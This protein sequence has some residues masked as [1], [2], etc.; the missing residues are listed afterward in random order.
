MFCRNC[1][2]KLAEGGKF[3]AACGE[4]IPPIH[5]KTAIQKSFWLWL[6]FGVISSISLL[7][8]ILVLPGRIQHFRTAIE[9]D[10]NRTQAGISPI[11]ENEA[12][13]LEESPDPRSSI[14]TP[15]V[16]PEIS[17]TPEIPNTLGKDI[18]PVINPITDASFTKKQFYTTL[19][20]DD[21]ENQCWFVT[22]YEIVELMF[23]KD[24]M[25]QMLQDGYIEFITLWNPAKYDD[26][27]QY[28][29]PNRYAI[30]KTDNPNIYYLS[31]TTDED[32]KDDVPWLKTDGKFDTAGENARKGFIPSSGYADYQLKKINNQYILRQLAYTNIG[33]TVRE[34]KNALFLGAVYKIMIPY[35]LPIYGHKTFD[36]DSNNGYEVRGFVD[37]QGGFCSRIPNDP[38]STNFITV[39]SAKN[40]IVTFVQA[41]AYYD[42]VP[43]D[44]HRLTSFEGKFRY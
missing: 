3:C 7:V 26:L 22:A 44:V 11:L 12:A 33:S 36:S 1:G 20:T 13:M 39:L 41:D 10:A 38:E 25:D 5:R 2:T 30:I 31:C 27:P 23:S 43:L 42:Q 29:Q 15:S 16:T 9:T 8:I 24:E 40:G 21:P 17:A 34:G 14:D 32:R 35:G 18:W 6:L 4:A 28:F 37:D 19:I